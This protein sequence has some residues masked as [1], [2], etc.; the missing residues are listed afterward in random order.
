MYFDVWIISPRVDVNISTTTGDPSTFP[1]STQPPRN[2]ATSVHHVNFSS[3]ANLTVL[4]CCLLLLQL[5]AT[6][7]QARRLQHVAGQPQSHRDCVVVVLTSHSWHTYSCRPVRY[8]PDLNRGKDT[9]LVDTNFFFSSFVFNWFF[10]LLWIKC[11]KS[12]P[13]SLGSSCTQ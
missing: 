13:V 12:A 7:T 1:Y 11:R 8:R 5:Q 4:L 10:F 3:S 9:A 6:H 2:P